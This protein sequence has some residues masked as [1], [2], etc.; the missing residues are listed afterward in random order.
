MFYAQTAA[1]RGEGKKEREKC[2]CR[3]VAL[4][5]DEQ[6][7]ADSTQNGMQQSEKAEINIVPFWLVP[8]SV[9]LPVNEQ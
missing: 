2:S 7:A 6:P 8:K 9:F 3:A 1:L 5:R 4:Q